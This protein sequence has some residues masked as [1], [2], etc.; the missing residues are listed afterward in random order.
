MWGGLWDTGIVEITRSH[1]SRNSHEPLYFF[2]T[3]PLRSFNERGTLVKIDRGSHAGLE[4]RM[5]IELHCGRIIC[6]LVRHYLLIK[7][8][9]HLSRYHLRAGY[10]GFYFS[11]QVCSPVASVSRL[12]TELFP[13]WLILV[14]ISRL[15]LICQQCT[16]GHCFARAMAEVHRSRAES[17][18]S[19][20]RSSFNWKIDQ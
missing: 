19:G 3:V 16:R 10:A 13:A 15:H 12:Q 18:S 7:I 5:R 20:A 6:R 4:T 8:H 11:E 9:L 2:S 17:W 14:Y 1:L